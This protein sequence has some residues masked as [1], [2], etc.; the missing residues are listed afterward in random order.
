MTVGLKG[1]QLINNSQMKTGTDVNV[2]GI[3]FGYHD[4]S[5]CIIQ[6]GKLVAAAEEERFTR[7]KHEFSIPQEA[8]LYCLQEAGISISDIDYLA[9]YENP[10]KKLARQIW[11]GLLPNTSTHRIQALAN[12][13]KDPN[14]YL[15]EI[16]EKLG[17]TGDIEFIDHHL[18]HAASSY[19]FSGFDDAAV[20]TIDSVGEWATMTYGYGNGNNLSIEEEVNF[21]DSIGLLYSA[22]T[23]YLGFDVNDGEYKVMGLAPYG[24]PKYVDKIYK[25]I[26]SSPNGQFRLNME[27]F[28]FLTDDRMYSNNLSELFGQPPRVPESELLDFHKDLAKSLQVVVEEILLQKVNYI[29]DKFPSDNLCMAGGVALNC[30]ANGRILREGP[31]KRLFIQPAAGDAGGALGAAA[32]AYLKLNRAQSIKPMENAY[33]GPSFT[34][35]YIHKVLE[36]T[37]INYLDF[38]ND[39]DQLLQ[40]VTCNLMEGKVVGWFQG[41]ME[42]GPRAL[43]SRSII[44]DPRDSGMR[45]LINALVKKRES[46]RPFAPSVLESKSKEHFDIDHASPYMLET[47]QVISDLDLPAITHVD[48]SARIQTV[49]S[50]TNPKYTALL[51]RFFER[52]GCPILLN[53]SFNMRGEPIV[54]TPL[55]AIKCFVKS[56][57]DV[58]VLEDFV[59]FQEDV[60]EIW[61]YF[62]NR[63]E[64]EQKVSVNNLVYTLL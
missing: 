17:Y 15:R 4:S 55:D 58:L 16:R 33:L 5:C 27:Y 26:E 6:N 7:N 46:F 41:R 28:S 54:C 45:D 12:R 9:Y 49:N 62:I 43:G 14:Q 51:E 22:V 3:S 21:P 42:F 2:V 50:K 30:V 53:T 11:M 52:T 8:F 19:Y 60:P 24:K 47:C 48:H 64:D 44:A 29:H 36:S 40:E 18:S 37:S 13:L 34:S 39:Q 10:S 38:R 57:L 59:I 31:F 35:D 1:V 20:M 63:T 56:K 23:G 25:L 32:V 61:E